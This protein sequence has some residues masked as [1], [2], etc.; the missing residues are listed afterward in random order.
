MLPD[1]AV[2]IKSQ[3]DRIKPLEEKILKFLEMGTQAGM[4]IDPD[5][6]TVTIYYRDDRSKVVLGN[7]DAIAIPELLPG[8]EVLVESLWPPVFE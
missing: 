8:W 7:G 4:L 2:E 6:E 1:L 3:S 5:E